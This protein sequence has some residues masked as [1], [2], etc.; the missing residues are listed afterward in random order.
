MN[1]EEAI[2]RKQSLDSFASTF[3]KLE[4][5]L[6]S[7]QQNVASTT[8][9]S[10]RLKALKIGLAALQTRWENQVYPYSAEETQEAMYVIAGLIPSLH[11]MAPKFKPSSSQATL[12]VRRVLSLELALQ[13]LGEM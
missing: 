7:V 11:A 5:A 13:V 12:L 8:V 9:V 1:H 6:T 2:V 10:K 3:H 4:K